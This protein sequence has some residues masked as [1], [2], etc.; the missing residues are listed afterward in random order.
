M[1][2]CEPKT[3][4]WKERAEQNVGLAYVFA[5]KYR[6]LL[7]TLTLEEA[8]SEALYAFVKAMRTATPDYRHE[9]GEVTNLSGYVAKSV[10]RQ[11]LNHPSRVRRVEKT[12]SLSAYETDDDNREPACLG[13]DDEHQHQT[14]QVEFCHHLLERASLSDEQRQVLHLHYWQGLSFKQI[15]KQMG[16][17]HR[18]IRDWAERA[19]L[20]L[21]GITNY[22]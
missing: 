12:C 16:Q 4:D 19:R 10:L 2:T 7:P 11:F 18:R 9:N 15:A 1:A 5:L 14:A 17:P 6:R 8:N 13:R 21:G 3:I 22:H 20:V